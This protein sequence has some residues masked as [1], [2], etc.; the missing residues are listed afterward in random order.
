MDAV[1]LVEVLDVHGHVQI[2]H[3]VSGV[4][5]QCRIGRSLSCDVVIDDAYAAAEHAL[6]TLLPDG[7]VRVQDLGTRNG[8]RVAG[9]RIDPSA[10]VTI[11][12]G[13]LHIG[14]TRVLLRT[15]DA[16][17]SPE[18]HFRRDLLHRHRTLFAAA[19][20]LLCFAFAAFLQWTFA[21]ERLAPRVLIAELVALCFLAVWVGVWALVSRLTAGAWQ[22]RI[23][24]AI[25]A[26][27]VG[28]CAWGY[29]LYLLAAFATQRS[30]LWIAL[31]SLAACVAMAA[32]YLHLHYAT[33][34]RR[35]ASL[36]LSLLAPLICS[37]VWWLVDLQLDPRTVNRVELGPKVYP[38]LMRVA[39]S[40]DLGDY[41]ADV[42][43]LKRE[44]NQNRQESLLET[45]IYDVEE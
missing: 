35:P 40:M 24:M 1:M 41:L 26:F 18:R 22:L 4:G 20:L 27:C 23:H 9:R 10:G 42:A 44:A 29:W 39:P 38:S 33:H 28:L 32:A 37:G 21:P 14:R 16:A 12:K 5:G 15:L 36:L 43:S 25:A 34:F 17:V 2:R 7:R 3:R 31:A 6:L 19:G 45:P 8:T 13:E 11:A 30:W